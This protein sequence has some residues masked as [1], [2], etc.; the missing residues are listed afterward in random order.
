MVDSGLKLF[1]S[2]G[3][4][5][6]SRGLFSPQVTSFP[7]ENARSESPAK[8]LPAASLGKPPPLDVPNGPFRVNQHVDRRPSLHTRHNFYWYVDEVSLLSPPSSGTLSH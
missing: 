8:T 7:P 2:K 5:L 3:L 1:D 4:R 6:R